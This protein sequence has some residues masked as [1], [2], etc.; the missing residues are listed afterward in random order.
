MFGQAACCTTSI[1]SSIYM[2]TCTSLLKLSHRIRKHLRHLR[3]IYEH[4]LDNII[5]LQHLL[6]MQLSY[7]FVDLNKKKYFLK[8]NEMLIS[9]IMFMT[10]CVVSTYLKSFLTWFCYLYW[11]VFLF[12]FLMSLYASKNFL[13]CLLSRTHNAFLRDFVN[14][15]LTVKSSRNLFLDYSQGFISYLHHLTR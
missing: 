7:I 12:F 2:Y 1:I 4:F 5:F 14:F 3:A 10:Y 8:T 6:I 13:Y 11:S 15:I 9:N